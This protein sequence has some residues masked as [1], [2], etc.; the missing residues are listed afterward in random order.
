MKVFKILYLMASFMWGMFPVATIGLL[1]HRLSLENYIVFS[2]LFLAT[3]IEELYYL[4]KERIID[5]I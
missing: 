5:V 3:L 4:I 1:I 2:I